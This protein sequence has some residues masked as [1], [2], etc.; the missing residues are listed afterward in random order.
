MSCYCEDETKTKRKTCVICKEMSEQLMDKAERYWDCHR[1]IINI[2]GLSEF[3]CNDCKT[4]GWYS[5]AGWGGGT[6]HINSITK[7]ER[8]P[9]REYEEV[10]EPW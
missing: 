10:N 4:E 7:E 1:E 2:C 8:Y 9:D 6:Q 3:V 5:T